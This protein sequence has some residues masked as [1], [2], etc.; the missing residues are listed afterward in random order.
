M[1]EQNITELFKESYNELYNSAPS[2]DEMH[3][4][5]AALQKMINLA[6][7]AEVEKLTGSI[8]K[9][10]VSK[11]KPQKTD[12]SGSYVSDGL[13]NVP[14]M[15]YDQLASMFRSWLYH[16]SVTP[17]LLACSFLPLLK[18]SLKD[19]ADTSSYRAIAG[20]SLI[21]KTFELVVILLWGHLL[22]LDTRPRH[23]PPTAHGW[24]QRLCNTC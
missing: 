13:K 12:V 15:L 8:V 21:L 16:G 18:S 4:L 7:K 14:D 9:E 24:C 5:K 2:L 1:G 22:S 10:A 11:L 6:S 20:S 19:P 3:S 23:P 17:S